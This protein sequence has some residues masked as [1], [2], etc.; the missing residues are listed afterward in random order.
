VPKN[1]E[2]IFNVAKIERQKQMHLF[3][4]TR[5]TWMS[6]MIYGA[7]RL[8]TIAHRSS[9]SSCMIVLTLC[10]TTAGKR[11]LP[12]YNANLYNSLPSNTTSAFL[13]FRQRLKAFLFRRSHLDFIIW[14]GTKQM[15][16]P[17]C[18]FSSIQN[19][20]FWAKFRQNSN[21]SP[22]FRPAI[23]RYL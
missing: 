6:K 2:N 15:R 1:H 23:E 17:R 20:E 5:C 3:S 8:T 19:H 21:F 9:S 12:I 11:T 16:H 10:H 13:V 7:A 14:P 4:E 18:H 22:K